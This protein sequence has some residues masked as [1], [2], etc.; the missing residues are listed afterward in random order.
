MGF[1]VGPISS[2]SPKAV[3]PGRSGAEPDTRLDVPVFAGRKS[4]GVPM[5]GLRL[6][7]GKELGAAIQDDAR[8]GHQ[9]TE[10]LPPGGQVG[11]RTGSECKIVKGTSRH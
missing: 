1:L 4:E 10:S 3:E 6:L 8:R 7:F 9:G 11:S 2:A 5:Q